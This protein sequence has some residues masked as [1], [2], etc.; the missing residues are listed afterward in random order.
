[1][2]FTLVVLVECL[3][4][5]AA[6]CALS[7]VFSQQR[8]PFRQTSNCSVKSSHNFFT[9]TRD[10]FLFGDCGG[11]VGCFVVVSDV[12]CRFQSQRTQLVV[13]WFQSFG[14]SL[15]FGSIFPFTVVCRNFMPSCVVR[16]V[17]AL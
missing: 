10:T 6:V 9:S 11:C 5:G 1:M 3:E 7:G 17:A 8:V 16:K 14:C 15:N 13:A 2:F 4:E 12:L